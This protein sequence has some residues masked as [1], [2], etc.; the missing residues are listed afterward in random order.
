M[1]VCCS[2]LLCV[3]V[4]CTELQFVVLSGPKASRGQGGVGGQM[5]VQG[6]VRAS[7]CMCVVLTRICTYACVCTCT[8]GH[9]QAWEFHAVSMPKANEIVA[10][11]H[12]QTYKHTNTQAFARYW[13]AKEV[14]KG[15]D[16]LAAFLVSAFTHVS[17]YLYTR[18]CIH[19]HLYI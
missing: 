17:M 9:M 10:E 6:G 8:R 11:T 19:V 1:L 18:M 7:L 5:S 15:I 3:V 4:Y 12:V 14:P 16:Y 2:V 13:R